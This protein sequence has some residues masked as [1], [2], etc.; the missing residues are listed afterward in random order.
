MNIFTEHPTKANETYLQHLRFAM[1]CG[2]KMMMAGV[3]CMLHAIFP[4]CC[5]TNASEF[6]IKM[7]DI[8]KKRNEAE[9]T[10]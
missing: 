4:F 6:V 9:K 8:L 7:H 5:K 3:S 2:F 10:Q 1:C